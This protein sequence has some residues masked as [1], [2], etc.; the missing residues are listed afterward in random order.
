MGR[1]LYEAVP[2]DVE[3]TK[4]TLGQRD[5]L[6]R[7][8]RHENINTF[9]GN[10]NTPLLIGATALVAATPILFN[11]F[12]NAAEDQGIIT[13]EQTWIKI[14]KASLLG[15]AGISQLLA[16][17]VVKKTGTIGGVDVGAPAK[18][19]S[20]LLESLFRNEDK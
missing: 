20:Q 14:Y 19:L 2:D 13:D 15:P 7:Y 1:P 17:E 16:E 4:L 18:T 12:R 10:Q 8:K 9:L 11:A 5:A 6:A 3:L